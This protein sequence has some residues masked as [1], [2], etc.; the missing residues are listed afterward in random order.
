MESG[1][2]SRH[3]LLYTGWIN[4]KVLLHGTGNCAQ[5]PVTNHK[6]KEH[7]KRMHIQ[8]QLNHCCTA[9]INTPQ[10]NYTA[11]LKA[12]KKRNCTTALFKSMKEI[13]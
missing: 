12:D 13:L 9:E 1:A 10:F 6:G 2:V 3:K 7:Y 5:Y 11:I 8:V 4:S